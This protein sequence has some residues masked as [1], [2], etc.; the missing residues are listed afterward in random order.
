MKAT[1][2]VLLVIAAMATASCRTTQERPLDEAAVIEIA[3]EALAERGGWTND[4]GEYKAIRHEHGWEV[5]VTWSRRISDRRMI[6]A[7]ASVHLDENGVVT[8]FN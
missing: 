5:K 8:G 1:V 7:M 4:D 6:G 2:H 3:R